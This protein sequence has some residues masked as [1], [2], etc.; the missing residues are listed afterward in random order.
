MKALSRLHPPL[1]DIWGKHLL[2][3]AACVIFCVNGLQKAETLKAVLQGDYQPDRFPA[4]SIRPT[5]G[6]LLWIVDQVA[7]NYL[8][9]QQE[10]IV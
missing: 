4:Q 8:Q 10:I 7:A 6:T 5:Q 9:T 2:N 1:K 3:N